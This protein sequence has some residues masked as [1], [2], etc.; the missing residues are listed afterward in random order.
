L[1]LDFLAKKGT[2]EILYI[3][4]AKNGM[5]FTEIK[6]LVGSPTTTSKCLQELTDLGLVKRDVQADQYRTVIYSLTE[7][8][9]RVVKLMK[10]LE[11]SL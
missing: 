10:E 6:E 3:L 2:K 9:I 4:T 8:G 11:H 7:K 5:K 1:N